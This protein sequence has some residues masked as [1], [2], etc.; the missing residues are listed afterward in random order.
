VVRIYYRLD[1]LTGLLGSLDDPSLKLGFLVAFAL[2]R[3]SNPQLVAL[4][5]PSSPSNKESME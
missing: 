5:R 1:Q 3:S 4:E 2:L